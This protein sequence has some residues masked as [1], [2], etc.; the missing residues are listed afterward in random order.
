M[1]V[2]KMADRTINGK[3]LGNIIK[4]LS[5]PFKPDDFKAN[6]YGYNYLPVEKFRQRMDEVVGILN[7]DFI[8]SEPQVSI[9]G[10][11]PHISLS[12]SITIRDDNGNIVTTKAACGGTQVI[13]SNKENEAVLF[14]NDLES[15]AADVFKRC[16]KSLGMAEAQLKQLRGSKGSN[17]HNTEADPTEPIAY[18]RVKLRETF[19][20][21]G[22]TGYGAMVEIE[23]ED[24][25]RKLMIW[26]SGQQEI[27]KHMPMANFIQMF[28]A[29]KVFCLYGTKT[30]FRKKNQSVE[31]QLNFERPY[32]G[33]D[34]GS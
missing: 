34:E 24:E 13:M 31:L 11:R 9:I 22:K 15:A 3:S 18:Y 25:P 14:K 12:G 23:G 26:K 16:C 29:G 32:T 1:E 8:T 30:V 2:F 19:A 33:N 28:T 4:E 20:S 5:N 17:E 10:S 27:E 21:V 6:L 7:Y